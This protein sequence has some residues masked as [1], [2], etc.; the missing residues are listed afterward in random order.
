MSLQK[1]YAYIFDKQG[2]SVS[3]PLNLISLS[4]SGSLNWG[5]SS[6]DSGFWLDEFPLWKCF[7]LVALLDCKTSLFNWYCDLS[8]Q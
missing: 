4:Q 7:E 1:T 3:R 8:Q 5:S 2:K 6:I